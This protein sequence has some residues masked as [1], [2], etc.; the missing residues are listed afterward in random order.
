MRLEIEK[1]LPAGWKISASHS[2]TFNWH[3]LRSRNI[4]APLVSES[5]PNPQTV[6]RPLGFIQ[7]ILQFETSG[8]ATGRVLYVGVNQNSNKYFNINAGYINFDFRTDADN[9]F[10]LPQSSYDFTGEWARPV[11][12]LRHRVFVSTT[13]N[14][15]YKLRL[16]AL[17]NAASGTPFNI[18]TGRDNN[19]DGNFNDR[20]SQ[21]FSTN[22]QLVPTFFGFLDPNVV[23]GN[24]RR[25]TGTNPATTLDLNLSRVF[26]V[27]K[28]SK[29]GDGRYKLTANIRAAN[30]LNRANLLGAVGILSSPFFGKPTTANPARRIEFGLR[31]NF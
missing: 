26:I 24:L 10:A 7:N 30:A 17:L 9:A 25:N 11:W 5:N 16:S 29:E 3:R 13:A 27:G 2:W 28:K 8:R 19:G 18:T 12:Q 21:S 15:P 22:P 1:Q 4:N 31:F 20:P 23:N 14:L 6:P